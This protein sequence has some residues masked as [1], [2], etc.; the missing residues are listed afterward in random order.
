MSRASNKYSQA[1]LGLWGEEPHTEGEEEARALPPS[2]GVLGSNHF[3]VHSASIFRSIFRSR[4]SGWK[5]LAKM[6]RSFLLGR[7]LSVAWLG[8][9]CRAQDRLPY[10]CRPIYSFPTHVVSGQK[11]ITGSNTSFAMMYHQRPLCSSTTPRNQVLAL[12]TSLS[13]VIT[14]ARV[15]VPAPPALTTR[16]TQ[17]EWRGLQK[18]A[19]IFAAAAQCRIE[20]GLNPLQAHPFRR[21]PGPKS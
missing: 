19:D 5:L 4:H 13:P 2:K 1:N 16:N 17:M 14:P 6:F 8:H 15:L 12:H 18:N 7:H 9:P 20:K 21:L 3:M 10:C 11:Y